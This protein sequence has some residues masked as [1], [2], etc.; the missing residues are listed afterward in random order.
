[1]AGL[2]TGCVQD[3]FFSEVNAATARVLATEGCEVMIL[4]PRRGGD[5]AAVAAG[6]G[7]GRSS[8]RPEP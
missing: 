7:P 3:V 6:D 4:D 5:L 2:L 8:L 1:M